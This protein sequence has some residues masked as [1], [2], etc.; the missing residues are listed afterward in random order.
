MPRAPSLGGGQGQEGRRGTL[1]D[2]QQSGEPRQGPMHLGEGAAVS[3]VNPL[4]L[5]NQL[6][7]PG[8]GLRESEKGTM[9]GAWGRAYVSTGMETVQHFGHRVTARETCSL[10]ALCVE[11]GTGKAAGAQERLSGHFRR[12]KNSFHSEWVAGHC[13]HLAQSPKAR[14]HKEGRLPLLRATPPPP[15]PAL[16]FH[17]ALWL[18]SQAALGPLWLPPSALFPPPVA[19]IL[20]RTPP[21]PRQGPFPLV[22]PVWQR[23]KLRWSC[24]VGAAGAGAAEGQLVGRETPDSW[25]RAPS[26]PAAPTSP[27]GNFAFYFKQFGLAASLPSC[28]V[29]IV[30][31]VIGN[32]CTDVLAR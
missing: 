22:L 4:F 24:R 1:R 21:S 14:G 28:W 29:F 13:F 17:T 8:G 25:C 30:R 11:G 32:I 18:H 15:L 23:R 20:T 7:G 9:W 31:K 10:S 6:R 12:Q 2:I 5:G 26:L 3:A 16:S 19:P 27:C